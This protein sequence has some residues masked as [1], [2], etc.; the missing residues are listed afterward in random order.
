[1]SD[2]GM[3]RVAPRRFRP[4]VRSRVAVLLLWGLSAGCGGP[5]YGADYLRNL[6]DGQRAHRAGRYD[7]AAAAFDRAAAQA[8]RVKD[9][10]EAWLLS[11]RS[12]GRKGDI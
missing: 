9:R 4:V 1:M 3:H 5:T 7:E 2:E 12:L 11:A 6:H 8:S 10:D